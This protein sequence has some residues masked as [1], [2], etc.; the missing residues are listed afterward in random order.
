MTNPWQGIKSG[1]SKLISEKVLFH[2]FYWYVEDRNNNPCLLFK[3]KNRATPLPQKNKLPPISY[4][5]FQMINQDYSYLCVELMDKTY[6]DLFGEFCNLLTKTSLEI[7]DESTA[8]NVFIKK[9]WRWQSL[10]S[11][12]KEKKLSEEKHKGLL[13]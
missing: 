12:T 6:I 5:K 2:D 3:I 1:K 4:I 11:K 13:G 7:E 8:L 10:L 9:A